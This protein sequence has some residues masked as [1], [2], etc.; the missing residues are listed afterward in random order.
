MGPKRKRGGL[1]QGGRRPRR[2]LRAQGE[3][4]EPLEDV[5]AGLQTWDNPRAQDAEARSS[6]AEADEKRQ[7]I[8]PAAGKRSRRAVGDNQPNSQRRGEESQQGSQPPTGSQGSSQSSGQSQTSRSRPERDGLEDLTEV[9]SGDEK[10]PGQQSRVGVDDLVTAYDELRDEN[11]RLKARLNEVKTEE[12]LRRSNTTV[13]A[14][15][16]SSTSP[17]QTTNPGPA[18]GS[19]GNP[20]VSGRATAPGFLSSVRSTQ[21]L[22]HAD[23]NAADR[24]MKMK[25]L[26]KDWKWKPRIKAEDESLDNFLKKCLAAFAWVPGATESE[27]I[28]VIGNQLLGTALT[29][30]NKIPLQDPLRSKYDQFAKQLK[31][32]H[33][34]PASYLT[35]LTSL[36]ACLKTP[37]ESHAAHLARFSGISGDVSLGAMTSGSEL[38]IYLDSIEPEIKQ[39]IRTSY[40]QA[41]DDPSKLPP[42]AQV[43]IWAHGI[44]LER[45]SAKT[46]PSRVTSSVAAQSSAVR[47]TASVVQALA[48]QPSPMVPVSGVSPF[49]RGKNPVANFVPNSKRPA[50]GTSVGSAPAPASS[51]PATGSGPQSTTTNPASQQQP[52]GSAGQSRPCWNCGQPGHFRKDCPFPKRQRKNGS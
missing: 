23:P 2:S 11:E 33:D 14:H 41:M 12:Y 31:D 27:V 40:R 3:G 42:L 45:H 18:L 25:K 28:D 10:R 21:A 24:V 17:H 30:F 34:P 37:N 39:E 4:P 7:T 16:G 20:Q 43:A 13:S 1:K 36:R 50:T 5:P 19:S 38:E 49:Y 46:P 32:L 52:A 48:G 35:A 51:I 22:Q 29:W 26:V 44:S 47:S 15:S 6:D 8:A 9:E